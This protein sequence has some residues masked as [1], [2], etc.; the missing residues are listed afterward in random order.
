MNL[1]HRCRV[2]RGPGCP[3]RSKSCDVELE[4]VA[5]VVGRCMHIKVNMLVMVKC[6]PRRHR[7]GDQ[8]G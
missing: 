5:Q 7:K 6:P 4:D 8:P 1:G 3:I 2:G